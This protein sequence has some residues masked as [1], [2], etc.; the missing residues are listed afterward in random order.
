MPGRCRMILIAAHAIEGNNSFSGLINEQKL[1]VKT[2][3]DP[4]RSVLFFR[5]DEDLLRFAAHLKFLRL[6]SISVVCA[7]GLLVHLEES[8]RHLGIRRRTSPRE[9]G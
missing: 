1:S 5:I 6:S 4:L 9:T 3:D 8:V 7:P 2:D